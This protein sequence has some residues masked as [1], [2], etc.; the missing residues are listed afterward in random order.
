LAEKPL[1]SE[2]IDMLEPSLLD[3]LICHMSSLASV[4]HK[5]PSTSIESSTGTRKLAGAA[6][7]SADSEVDLIGEDMSVTPLSLPSPQVNA[8]KRDR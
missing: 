4:H 8:R 2:K 1:I 6:N 5:P 7:V 3:E